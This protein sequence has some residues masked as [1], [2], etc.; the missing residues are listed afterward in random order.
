MPSTLKRATEAAAAFL[1]S[2]PLARAA[3]AAS[4][5]P[6]PQP[7]SNMTMT[8]DQEF[9]QGQ[10]LDASIW[11]MVTSG[12]GNHPFGDPTVEA[13]TYLPAQVSTINQRGLRFTITT[14]S[15][16]TGH[17]YK[18]GAVSTLGKWSQ[19]Y[20]HFEA[21]MRLPET[22]GLWPAWWLLPADNTWPPELDILEDIYAVNGVVPPATASSPN[23]WQGSDLATTTHWTTDGTVAGHKQ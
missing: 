16:E 12:P 18:S 3:P 17:P 23:P 15:P 8:L 22:N 21:S 2:A 6:A 1:L 14:G 13:E 19:L 7:A 10:A 9:F 5:C 4:V 11:N 20:G